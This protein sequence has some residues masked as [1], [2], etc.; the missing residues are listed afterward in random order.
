MC[1]NYQNHFWHHSENKAIEFPTGFSN[2]SIG[3]HDPFSTDRKQEP[4]KSFFKFILSSFYKMS[5]FCEENL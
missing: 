2:V 4:F 5:M 1:K 3:F